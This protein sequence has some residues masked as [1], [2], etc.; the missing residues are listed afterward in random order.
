MT[1][2]R[3]DVMR[4]TCEHARRVGELML[5]VI[6]YLQGRAICHDASKFTADEFDSFAE[7]TPGLKDLTYGSEE[8]KE[9]LRKIKP[10]IT[11]HYQRNRHH[12]EHFAGGIADMT[13]IDL[14]EMLADWRAAGERHKG[15]DLRASIEMNAERFGYNDTLKRLLLL[16]ASSLGWIA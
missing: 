14:M 2:T 13:L 3:D 9:Q 12:P 16:T 11:I 10:A 4:G 15:G 7:V 6:N 8:Y 5:Q 1:M